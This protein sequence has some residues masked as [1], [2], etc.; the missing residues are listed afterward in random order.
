MFNITPNSVAMRNTLEY[1]K[2]QAK[3]I[4]SLNYEDRVAKVLEKL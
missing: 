3:Y 1:I 2:R 4:T